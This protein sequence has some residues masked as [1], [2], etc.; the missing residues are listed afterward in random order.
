MSISCIGEK[1]TTNKFQY[2]MLSIY[3]KKK[4]TD[5]KK[6]SVR[7]TNLRKKKDEQNIR[8]L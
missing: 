3:G 8:H 7:E 5:L 1:E 4:L 6:S 2:K